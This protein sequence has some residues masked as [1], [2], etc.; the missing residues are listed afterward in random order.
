M[1]PVPDDARGPHLGWRARDYAAA[2]RWQAEYVRHRDAPDAWERPT[3]V[4]GPPVVL[5]P[6]VYERWTFLRPL[7]VHLHSRGVRVHVVPALG[8]NARP[9]ESSA[10]LLGA[11]LA[12]RDLRDVVL[13]AHS[14][15]GLI[16]KL[17]MS[18]YDPDGRVARMV[19]VN[20][21]FD[22]STLARWTVAPALRAFRP[23]HPTI[24][25]LAA[26]RAVNERIVNVQSRWDP[27]VP[28]GSTLPGA[29]E[30]ELA[31][32]GHFHPLLDPRLRDVLAD[33]LGLPP[34]G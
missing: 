25:A 26:E 27:H 12:A 5:V 14:K 10:Q 15:G 24:R 11:Y 22:G 34:A 6:G 18:R 21:P 2:V 33:V 9:V 16:G 29:V 7:A 31:T 20:T 1:G 23:A 13:V 4:A 8:R 32:P 28:G 17:T 3:R 19:A 30:V